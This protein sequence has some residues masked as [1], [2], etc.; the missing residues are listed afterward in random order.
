MYT[1]AVKK[2]AYVIDP[3]CWVSYS[4]KP[5]NFKRTMESR[6]RASLDQASLE[7]EIVQETCVCCGHSESEKPEVTETT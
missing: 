1:E 7:V 3:Q 4:G 6:R 5:I 2:R